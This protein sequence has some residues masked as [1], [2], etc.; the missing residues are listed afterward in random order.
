M[1]TYIFVII[2]L[3]IMF[4]YIKYAINK[5]YA[6]LKSNYD[7][8]SNYDLI[9]KDPVEIMFPNKGHVKLYE[10]M[11]WSDLAFENYKYIRTKYRINLK[12]YDI[13]VPLINDGIKREVLIWKIDTQST[14]SDF[15]NMYTEPRFAHSIKNKLI[16]HVKAGE[17]ARGILTEPVKIIFIH[18]NV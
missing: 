16:L 17:H 15:Y 8:G 14:E 1:Q 5:S 11:H 7:F 18:S 4:L 6:D 2:I 13:Y 12:S 3:L 9:E 10:D